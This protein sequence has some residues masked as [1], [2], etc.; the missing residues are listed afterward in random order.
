MAKK[1]YNFLGHCC[2]M[3]FYP[4]VFFATQSANGDDLAKLRFLGHYRSYS[5]PKLDNPQMFVS[6][7]KTTL[8]C[9]CYT[10]VLSLHYK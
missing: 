9:K 5:W 3:R 6:I 10:N 2:F 4:V 8:T 7:C 1:K